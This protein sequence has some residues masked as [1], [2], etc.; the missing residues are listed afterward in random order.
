MKKRLFL[1]VGLVIVLFSILA[2]AWIYRTGPGDLYIDKNGCAQSHSGGPHPDY[3]VG[4]YTRQ[5][6]LARR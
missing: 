3:C 1:I 4:K 6:N 2:A 5:A